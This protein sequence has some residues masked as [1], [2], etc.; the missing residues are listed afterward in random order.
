MYHHHWHIKKKKKSV[1]CLA[2]LT[3]FY[4]LVMNTMPAHAQSSSSKTRFMVF[5]I[6]I[7]LNKLYAYHREVQAS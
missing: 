3:H 2:D 4:F 5:Y 1:I 6:D 7:H